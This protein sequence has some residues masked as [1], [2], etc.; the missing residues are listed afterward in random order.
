MLRIPIELIA[1]YGESSA[2]FEVFLRVTGSTHTTDSTI[3]KKLHGSKR[4]VCVRV[5]D[6]LSTFL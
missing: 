3:A 1:E 2:I 5:V 4:L 6:F